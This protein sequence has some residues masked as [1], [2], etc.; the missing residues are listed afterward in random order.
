MKTEL[1]TE[2]YGNGQKR[3]EGSYKDGK[4]D[5]LWTGWYENGQQQFEGKYKD[6]E[7]EGLWTV[8]YECTPSAPCGPIS[9]IA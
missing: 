9:Q 7:M 2:Y 6:G 8:W 5:G 3:E 1:E 4:K